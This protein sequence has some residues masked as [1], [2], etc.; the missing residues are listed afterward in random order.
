MHNLPRQL[1]I[2]KSLCQTITKV[3]RFEDR[4]QNLILENQLTIKVTL[5]LEEILNKIYFQNFRVI[6]ERI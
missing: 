5:S 1:L 6:E 4:Y 3:I 2:I